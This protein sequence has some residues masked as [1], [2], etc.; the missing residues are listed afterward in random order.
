M[1]FSPCGSERCFC[2]VTFRNYKK[3]ND[4]T[5]F[6]LTNIER[7]NRLSSTRKT[8]SHALSIL[9]GGTRA[10]MITFEDAAMKKFPRQTHVQSDKSAMMGGSNFKF[11]VFF[12]T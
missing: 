8:G 10:L 1:V 2:V 4:A 3:E 11:V 5:N 6:W 9:R 7:L 12:A